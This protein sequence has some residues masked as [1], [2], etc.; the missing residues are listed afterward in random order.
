MVQKTQS[1]GEFGWGG[2]SAK[3]ITQISCGPKE[4]TAHL[5]SMFSTNTNCEH[6]AYRPRF[7]L[8]VQ[9]VGWNSCRRALK[10]KAGIETSGLELK[11][12]DWN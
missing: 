8:D 6:M 1:G 10:A 12:Q 11:P 7:Q 9:S 2:T 3:W 4:G 5:I